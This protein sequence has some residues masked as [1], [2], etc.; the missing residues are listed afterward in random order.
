MKI[1]P[2]ENSTPQSR[3]EKLR[4][5]KAQIDAKIRG[6][7]A[8]QQQQT[9]KNETRKKIIAGALALHHLEKNPEDSFSKK[10]NSLLNEY[11]TKPYERSLFGLPDLPENL[12]NEIANDPGNQTLDLRENFQ[13]EK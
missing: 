2:M 6:I 8:R 10:L 9:R 7:E 13:A 5:Q 11:V 4:Q 1:Y 12:Q 3:L